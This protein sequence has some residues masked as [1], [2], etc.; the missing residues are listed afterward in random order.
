MWTTLLNRILIL[1]HYVLMIFLSS[2]SPKLYF[3]KV[4]TRQ[5]KC[6]IAVITFT[7]RGKYTADLIL[8]L[9][10]QCKTFS[11]IHKKKII[12]WTVNFIVTQ[13][14][15]STTPC[16]RSWLKITILCNGKAVTQLSHNF[17]VLLWTLK[18]TQRSDFKATIHLCL[19][20]SFLGSM[21]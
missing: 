1:I 10:V 14:W 12:R 16:F 17:P 7:V 21:H 15:M 3:L 4:Y 19:C 11:K 2:F 6:L 8:F 18:E 9:P 13:N 20:V 5:F